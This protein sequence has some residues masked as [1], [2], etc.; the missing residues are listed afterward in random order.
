MIQ[1][2]TVFVS[3]YDIWLNSFSD[4]DGDEAIME[5]EEEGVFHPNLQ[6]DHEIK[7]GPFFR[8]SCISVGCGS[9]LFSIA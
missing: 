5:E 7:Q 8:V 9:T 4:S 6:L 2:D 1:L 3:L